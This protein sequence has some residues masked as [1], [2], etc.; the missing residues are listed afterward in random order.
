MWMDTSRKSRMSRIGIVVIAAVIVEAISVVQ[1]QRLR[2]MM[3]EEMDTRSRV[4]VG[5]MAN[6][7]AHTL[8][9]TTLTMY[10]NLWEVQR[11]LP[12]PD[13]VFQALVYLIDD[14]PHVSGGC[15]AFVPDY[16]PSKGRL[17]EQYASKENCTIVLRQIAG[18]DHDYTENPAYRQ[19]VETMAPFW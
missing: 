7:I 14:N 3:Q 1:Y 8:E 19:A 12:H 9:L 18:P 4:V 16:Y 11:S 15:L 5:S 10:E 13:S 2:A 17:F 6:E